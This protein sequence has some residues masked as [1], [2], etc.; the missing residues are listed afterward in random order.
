MVSR[1]R[2]RRT[3]AADA[4][5]RQPPRRAAAAQADW[6][7]ARFGSVLLL[8]G[9]C[10]DRPLDGA[11]APRPQSPALAPGVAPA[12]QGRG[13]VPADAFVARA[14]RT[15]LNAPDGLARAEPPLRRAHL[16]D[17]AEAVAGRPAGPPPPSGTPTVLAQ[18]ANPILDVQADP[19]LGAAL[20]A[21]IDDLPKSRVDAWGLAAVPYDEQITNGLCEM[22]G[23]LTSVEEDDTSYDVSLQIGSYNLMVGEITQDTFAL[24]DGCAAALDANG[25]DVDAATEAGDC[26]E[27][28]QYVY[29]GGAGGSS[30]C[31]TCVAGDTVEDCIAAGE[32]PSEAQ[33]AS[34]VEE[35]GVPVWYDLMDGFILG[36][37]PDWTVFVYL[38]GHTQAD[39]TMPPAFDH[40]DWSYICVPFWDDATDAASF[41]CGSGDGGPELGDTLGE[42]VH[43]AIDHLWAEGGDQDVQ[44]W[45]GRLFYASYATV[46][47]SSNELKWFWDWN[48]GPGAVSAPV[49]EGADLN[50]DGVHDLGDENWGFSLGATGYGLGLNPYALRPD[51]TDPENPDDTYARDWVATEAIKGSTTRNGIL[52]AVANH[53][54]C[55][56]W[57]PA[58]DPGGPERCAAVREPDAG[59]L[60]DGNN[61]TAN[62]T[63]DQSYS[64][65]IVTLASNGLPDPDV[66]GGWATWEAGSPALAN[67]DWDACTWP[68][69]FTPDEMVV[70]D[71]PD[72]YPGLDGYTGMSLSVMTWRFGKDEEDGSAAAAGGAIRE[73]ISTDIARGYCPADASGVGWRTFENLPEDP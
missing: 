71:V 70:S 42:G 15:G 47:H 30:D 43:G 61:V 56:D 10:V 69:S 63:F 7:A 39:G 55:D 62:D 6:P 45:H 41:Y 13:D 60:N 49:A 28:E 67:P 11:R 24:S 32:C 35:D 9:A 53:N 59:W 22:P 12:W 50:G 31:R 26:S 18:I 37:A 34:W 4:G 46:K 2:I 72:T 73:V 19:D 66:P 16:A 65:A 5:A 29:F 68:H 27:E 14:P 57:D 51:G 58:L 36:C 33:G 17:P 54:R 25:G 44:P 48:P 23:L 52:I 20:D 21:Y 40:A 64:A 3:R 38:L 8:V 1:L